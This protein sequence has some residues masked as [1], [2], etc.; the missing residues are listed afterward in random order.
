MASHTAR[1]AR[2]F[3]PEYVR[4]INAQIVHPAHSQVVKP[5]ELESALAR[6]LN[7]S[8][9]EP[10]RPAEYLAATL[11]YGLIKGHPFLDGN[12]RT[13]FFL[14]NEYL[15]ALGHPGLLEGCQSRG[16]LE[17]VADRH[18]NAAAG[19]LDVNGLLGM[20]PS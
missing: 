14:A 19:Q 6:P 7:V 17:R 10:E 1:L 3:T 13:A 12:K 16:D 15:R 5:N 2:V 9:Y 11:S 20:T 4:R 8:R 18:I